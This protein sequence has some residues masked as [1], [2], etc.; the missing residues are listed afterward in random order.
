MKYNPSSRRMFLQG[1]GGFLLGVPTLASLLAKTSRAE[2]QAV[3]GTAPIRY[4][5]WVTNHGQFEKNF[6]PSELPTDPA[7]VNGVDVPGVKTR[8]LSS[9]GKLSQVIGEDFD[10][11]RKKMNLIRGLDLMVA[12]TLHNCC[13]P[14][15][16]SWPREDNN[17]PNVAYSV[18]HIM[19]KSKTVYPTA[20]RVPALR[21][22]PGNNSAFRSG[23]F[24]WTTQNGKPTRLPCHDK[25]QAAL[26]AVFPSGSASG[27]GGADPAQAAKLRLTD[28]VIEDY[29]SV[30]GGTTLSAVDKAQLSNYMDL[31][32]DVQNRAKIEAPECTPPSQLSQSDFVVLHKNAIDIAVAAM[33]CGATRIVAY[34]TYQGAPAS[35][36]E[37]TFH[38]WAH[39]DAS[40]HGPLQQWRYGRLAQ[41]I[42]TMDSFTDVN[43]KTL[44][45]NSL[46]YAC[47]ELSEPGHGAKHL[48]NMPIITAGSAGG[49]L[50]TGEYI[51][52]GKRLF[53]NMLVTNF[54][55]MGMTNPAEY[56]RD[57][58][59]GFGEYTG[60]NEGTYQAYLSDAE[61]RKPLP[62]LFKG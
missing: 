37:F 53:N 21:L 50:V 14:T 23:S 22:F 12:A 36:D 52:F 38:T 32:A 42:K 20:V 33:L 51:D 35:Y 18:D 7:K 5:Q 9:Y 58:R 26:N 31:L 55:A 54:A 27:G 15:C 25:T 4:V 19:E 16:A 39:N 43:G 56:E 30:L 41:L 62:Y 6:W 29:R 11:V 44:L 17:I 59:V 3:T 49:R 24:C 48:Q 46:V 61:R 8:A 28:Q 34:H 2:A 57:G 10:P 45:D 40:K 1:A 60:K 47:N 13:V